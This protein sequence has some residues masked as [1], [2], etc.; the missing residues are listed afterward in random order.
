[1]TTEKAF[2]PSVIVKGLAALTTP[3]PET[4]KLAGFEPV[5]GSINVLNSMPSSVELMLPAPVGT[6]AVEE[7]GVTVN[8]ASELGAE[9]PGMEMIARYFDPLSERLRKSV[10]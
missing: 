5:A 10:V 6:A 4:V 9:E 1:L 7:L 8:V 2:T 3:P